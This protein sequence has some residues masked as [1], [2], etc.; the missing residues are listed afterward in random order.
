MIWKVFSFAVYHATKLLYQNEDLYVSLNGLN[1]PFSEQSCKC[2]AE[3]EYTEP[4]LCELF[5]RRLEFADLWKTFIIP[6]LH[7]WMIEKNFQKFT[8]CS[9]PVK[10]SIHWHFFPFTKFQKLKFQNQCPQ[11]VGSE[12]KKERNKKKKIPIRPK[13]NVHANSNLL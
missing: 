10:L 5:G 11:V 7:Y 2:R 4:V 12:I 3:L 8:S 1:D 6:R 13:S 9:G